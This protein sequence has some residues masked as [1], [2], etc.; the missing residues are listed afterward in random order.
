[1]YDFWKK[2]KSHRGD[3]PKFTLPDL[4]GAQRDHFGRPVKPGS[5]VTSTFN[6][7]RMLCKDNF[8]PGAFPSD[9]TVAIWPI[10]EYHLGVLCGVSPE[11]RRKHLEAARQLSL[12]TIHWLQTEAPNPATGGQGYPGLRPRGD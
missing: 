5:Y 11:E 7:R 12:S 1:D 8:V 2:A 9:I 6:F 3:F 4:F 10:N